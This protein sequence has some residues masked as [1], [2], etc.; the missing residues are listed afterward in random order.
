MGMD[1]C[2]AKDGIFQHRRPKL[3]MVPFSAKRCMLS[4][5]LNIATMAIQS[6]TSAT[7]SWVQSRWNH[8]WPLPCSTR[9]ATPHHQPPI[10]QRDPLINGSDWL[11]ECSVRL[12]T[13]IVSCMVGRCSYLESVIIL[14]TAIIHWLVDWRPEPKVALPCQRGCPYLF[15]DSLVKWT[16]KFEV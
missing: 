1:I 8:G 2:R 12:A 14:R 6:P 5:V 11:L 10:C 16:T 7:I 4:K 15:V 3:H 9:L 13:H